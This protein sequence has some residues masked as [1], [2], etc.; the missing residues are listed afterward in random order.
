MALMNHSDGQ[1]VQ[2]RCV[3]LAKNPPCGQVGQLGQVDLLDSLK[4]HVSVHFH[5]GQDVG[6]T[7]LV[8]VLFK[9]SKLSNSPG[10]GHLGHDAARRLQPTLTDQC[11]LTSSQSRAV[12]RRVLE[13]LNEQLGIDLVYGNV[14]AIREILKRKTR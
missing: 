2:D 6:E 4:L 10:Q 11:P 12:A 9:V 8:C 1:L 13:L 5:V 7:Y 14:E 3:N